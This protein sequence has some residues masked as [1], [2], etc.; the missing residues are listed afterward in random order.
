MLG[1][2]ALVGPVALTIVRRLPASARMAN[3][4]R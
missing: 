1:L 3:G 4:K 2:V